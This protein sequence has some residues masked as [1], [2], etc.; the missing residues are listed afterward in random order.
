MTIVKAELAQAARLL[1]EPFSILELVP[2]GDLSLR[3]VMC[4]GAL[5][6]H[7][8]MD[9]DEL[10]LVQEGELLLESE[11]G[12][13]L[14]GP[15]ELAVIPKGVGHRPNSLRRSLVLQF[16]RKYMADRRNGERRIFAG[17]EG[18][19]VVKVNIL[20]RACVLKEPFFPCPVARVDDAT[21]SVA[22]WKG[23]SSWVE[24]SQEKVALL[25]EGEVLL[26][27]EADQVP[28]AS[29]ELVSIPPGLFYRIVA[30]IPSTALC[31]DC[32]VVEE[33]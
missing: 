24:A 19:A 1:K 2:L 30:R 14:L 8:H 17:P 15:G 25:W 4:Q 18:H 7:K 16:E 11:W 3:M 20:E 26:E 12:N 13:N 33:A 5:A 23:V 32:P 29:K 21:V 28:L 31:F 10:F 27:T 22:T 6:W 9:L